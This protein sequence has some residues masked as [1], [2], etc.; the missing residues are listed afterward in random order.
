[1]GLPSN[2]TNKQTVAPQ[3]HAFHTSMTSVID[4]IPCVI[5]CLIRVTNCC[6]IYVQVANWPLSSRQPA[7]Q[8][9]LFSPSLPLPQVVLGM[10]L[11]VTDGPI[12]AYISEV[13][14]ESLRGPLGMLPHIFITANM[15]IVYGV[16]SQV[17][18]RWS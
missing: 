15:L 14:S 3:L 5:V 16:S 1:M 17:G 6:F 4:D 10:A 2:K 18:G 7:C 11:G 8:P 13:T 12:R 9:P